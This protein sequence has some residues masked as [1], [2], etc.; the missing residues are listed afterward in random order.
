[1]VRVQHF[2]PQHTEDYDCYVARAV[3]LFEVNARP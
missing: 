3:L 1:M 2:A